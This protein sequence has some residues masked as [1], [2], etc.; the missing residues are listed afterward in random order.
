MKLKLILEFKNYS[1]VVC[2]RFFASEFFNRIG[3]KQTFNKSLCDMP[4]AVKT[5]VSRGV[6]RWELTGATTRVDDA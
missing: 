2:D 3:Q 1:L 5:P 6:V 4:A